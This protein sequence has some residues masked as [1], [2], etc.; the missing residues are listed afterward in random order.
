[1]RLDVTRLKAIPILEV[2]DNSLGD[3]AGRVTSDRHRAETLAQLNALPIEREQLVWLLVL[4]DH[5]GKYGLHT[6]FSGSGGDFAPQVL[7]SLTEAG[8]GGRARI[9]ARAMRVFGTPYPT[10]EEERKP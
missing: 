9:F 2:V 10:A 4:K 3:L 1:M 6:F 8:L 5:W 7:G